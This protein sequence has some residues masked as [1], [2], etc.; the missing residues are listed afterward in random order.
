MESLLEY[1]HVLK[2]RRYLFAVPFIAVIL[3]LIVFFYAL[4]ISAVYRSEAVI[5]IEDPE[6]PRDLVGAT[7]TNYATQQIQLISRRLFTA[8]NIGEIVER[9]GIYRQDDSDEPMPE[10]VIVRRFRGDMDLQLVS[11]EVLDARGQSVEAAV[12]FTL[13]FKSP[14]PAMSQNVAEEI[15]NLF[16]SENQ[17][18]GTS[19]TMDVSEL[20][21]ASLSEAEE[22]LFAAETKLA[23]FKANNEG[24]LPE[25]YQLNLTVIN[26]SEQQLS[27]A[28]RRLQ[29]LRQRKL[30]LSS[31]LASLSPS[32][33]VTLPTGE[34]IMSDR[35]R[36]RALLIDYRRKSAIYEA[37]H[38]DLL[39]LEQ[40]I[41]TLQGLVGEAQSYSLIREQLQQERDK[42]ASMRDRYSEDH[43]DIKN[44]ESAIVQLES[45]LAG[46]DPSSVSEGV[47]ADNPA[48]IL[49][50]TQLQSTDLEIQSLLDKRRELLATISEHETLIRQ[51]PRVEMQY[52]MLLR[53]ANNARTKYNDLQ[54]K[55]R[56]ADVAMD[57]EQE[58]TGQ[59]FTVIEPPAFPVEP[60]PRYRLAILLLGGLMAGGIGIAF[61]IA[62]ELI[63]TTIRSAKALNEIVGTPP[64]AVI[65]YLDNSADVAQSRSRLYYLLATFVAVTA[66]S[67][68]YAVYGM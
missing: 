27:D 38:P 25:L 62:A 39:R 34:T 53:D 10:H 13:A 52:E 65:P 61:V 23:E 6:I 19:R 37:G 30:Q 41:E 12:A 26:R 49:I 47:I 1:W 21:T 54:A 33:P 14:D 42:L 24:A 56:A 3:I 36:L 35:D 22:Q 28:D 67:I 60:E 68:L 2:R 43:P 45:Q 63:D 7:F 31:E 16:L 66:L 58:I 8:K 46:I 4:G 5:L 51:A 32:A 9:L 50:N 64:L 29:E 40:E 20:L 48:Y 57:V 17:R 44:A 18:S 15:V 59:R 55:L 11:E